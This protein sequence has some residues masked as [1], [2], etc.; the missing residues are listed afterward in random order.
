MIITD[1]GRHMQPEDFEMFQSRAD[2]GAPMTFKTVESGAATSVFAA[3]SPSLQGRG[4]VYLEDCHVADVEDDNP[5]GGVRS[6]AVDPALA[7]QL[8]TVSEQ[9]VGQT[10][11]W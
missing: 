8:W 1:L 5:A 7:A 11:D 2:S 4:A 9:M 6:Y 10:F 3:T